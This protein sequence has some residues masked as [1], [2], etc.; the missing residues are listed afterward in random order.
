MDKEFLVLAVVSILL[1]VAV[2]Q[3]YQLS[4][5]VGQ[6]SGPQ[7]GALAQAVDPMAGHHDQ[8]ATAAAKPAGSGMVGGC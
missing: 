2:V 8:P 1:V 5:L 7:A 3:A 4:G 6:V